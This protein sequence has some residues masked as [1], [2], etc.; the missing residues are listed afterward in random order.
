MYFDGDLVLPQVEQL[1]YWLDFGQREPLSYGL[2]CLPLLFGCAFWVLVN[3]LP[4]K[5]RRKCGSASM[6]DAT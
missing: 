1:L 4:I 3:G 2:D 5:Q 6:I